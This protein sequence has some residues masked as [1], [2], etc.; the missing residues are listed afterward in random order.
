MYLEAD[1]FILFLK[2]C[3]MLLFKN[4]IIYNNKLYVFPNGMSEMRDV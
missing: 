1:F 3:S 4:P 2:R